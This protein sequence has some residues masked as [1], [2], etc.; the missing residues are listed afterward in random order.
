M[1]RIVLLGTPRCGSRL[2]STMLGS[3]PDVR[4][5]DEPFNA[6]N[7]RHLLPY[8][9]TLEFSEIAAMGRDYYE[10]F[11]RQPCTRQ[12][13][14]FSHHLRTLGW[15]PTRWVLEDRGARKVLIRRNNLL[16]QYVSLLEALQTQQWSLRAGQDRRQP[17]PVQVDV[18]E[19]VRYADRNLRGWKWVESYLLRTGQPYYCVVYETVPYTRL[20]MLLAYLGLAERDLSPQVRKQSVCPLSDRVLNWSE[21]VQQLPERYRHFTEWADASEVT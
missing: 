1:T 15:K 2:V 20:R 6:A 13:L 16:A 14:G 3:H 8:H 19:F 21:L 11:W 18:D 12:V 5:W 10:W 4:I 7:R 17:R 9:P